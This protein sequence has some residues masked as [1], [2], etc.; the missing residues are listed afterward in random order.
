MERIEAAEVLMEELEREQSVDASCIV[1]RR[2]YWVEGLE[3]MGSSK[4]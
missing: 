3:R 1:F 2:L 4:E